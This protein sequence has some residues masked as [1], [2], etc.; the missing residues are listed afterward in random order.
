M[1]PPNSVEAVESS[2]P[3]PFKQY[4][5]EYT[6]SNVAAGIAPKPPPP[7]K[8]E[9]T[10][11]GV[12]YNVD[13]VIIRPL[14]SQN[15][16]RLYPKQYDKRKELKKITASIICSFID[17]VNIL[18]Q[19]PNDKSRQEKLNDIQLLF[20][21]LHHVINEFRPHQA[22]ETLKV[23]MDL[24]KKEVIQSSKELTEGINK[25][26]L[27]ISEYMKEQS[28]LNAETGADLNMMDIDQDEVDSSQSN[29]SSYQSDIEN[30]NL[31]E[32]LMN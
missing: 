21:N 15:M 18:V 31:L 10:M 5:A 17:L 16:E 3:L 1:Q 26:N 32:N 28:L 24:Q 12:K 20:I 2:M 4:W 23:M 27:L 30:D 29:V 11:F 8:G 14:E 22:R 6:T 25:A 9:Y 7:I 13:D 19:C